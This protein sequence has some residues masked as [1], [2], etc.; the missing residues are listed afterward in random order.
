[1]PLNDDDLAYMRET[2]AD[3]RPSTATVHRATRTSDGLGGKAETSAS[4]EVVAIRIDSEAEVPDAIA[5]EFGVNVVR[6]TADLVSL[7][8]GDVLQ[9]EGGPSYRIVSDGDMDPWTTAQRLW[10]VRQE[11][12][13]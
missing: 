12:P 11:P 8:H 9:V 6:V 3:H 5:T 4:G 10:A 7:N 1:M 2:Q 13:G